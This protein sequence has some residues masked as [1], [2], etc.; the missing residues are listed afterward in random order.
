MSN[1]RKSYQNLS[2]LLAGQVEIGKVYLLAQL[3][4]GITFLHDRKRFKTMAPPKYNTAAMTCGNSSSSEVWHLA[5]QRTDRVGYRE[6]V[7]VVAK[8]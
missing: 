1:I 2:V 3:P 8:A 5:A 7:K 4:A 6:E